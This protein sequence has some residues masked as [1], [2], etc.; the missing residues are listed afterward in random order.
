M[1]G[2]PAASLPLPT[3]GAFLVEAPHFMSIE[4]KSCRQAGVLGFLT[5]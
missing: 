4:N 5:L 2:L 1:Q 3:S